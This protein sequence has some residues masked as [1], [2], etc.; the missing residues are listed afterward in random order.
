VRPF[1]LF[2]PPFPPNSH[3]SSVAC[4]WAVWLLAVVA[5]LVARWVLAA[6]QRFFGD[7]LDSAQARLFWTVAAG[8]SAAATAASWGARL[9]IP[10]GAWAA[11]LALAAALAS[12]WQARGAGALRVAL[13]A[14]AATVLAA[15]GTAACL[16]AARVDGLVS[17]AWAVVLLPLWLA[18]PAVMLVVTCFCVLISRSRGGCWTLWDC[19]RGESL[20]L[21]LHRVLC[22]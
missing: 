9:A 20:L 14:V 5:L 21:L 15:T 8:G 6:R 16:A 2:F 10:G 11:A 4:A 13:A 17:G 12:L 7:D 19:G 18:L 3:V 1:A 22:L